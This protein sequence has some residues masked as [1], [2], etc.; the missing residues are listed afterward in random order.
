[1]EAILWVRAS[2]IRRVEYGVEVRIEGVRDRAI[3]VSVF[4][5]R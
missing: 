5:W 2:R 4:L 1:M 3:F